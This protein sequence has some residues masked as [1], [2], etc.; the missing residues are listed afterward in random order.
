MKRR[1]GILAA[2]LCATSLAS[3]GGCAAEQRAEA[4][5][6]DGG[7]APAPPPSVPRG[8]YPGP[9]VCFVEAQQRT[10]LLDSQAFTLCQ[11]A[12]GLGPVACYT[13]ARRTYFTD[14]QRIVLCRCAYG[15]EPVDCVQFL[16]RETFLTDREVL[17][18]CSPTISGRLLANCLPIGSYY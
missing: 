16:E 17:E 15:T 2:F 8:A 6:M 12:Q 14:P 13:A 1:H 3:G 10:R 9:A 7:V 4:Q 5:G 11:G 18:L